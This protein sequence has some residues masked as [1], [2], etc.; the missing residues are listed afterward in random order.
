MDAVITDLTGSQGAIPSQNTAQADSGLPLISPRHF[1]CVLHP[2]PDF[3][4]A[5]I[6]LGTLSLTPKFDFVTMLSITRTI[7]CAEILF[8]QPLKK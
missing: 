1:Y 3:G 5:I 8:V 7:T 2:F 6:S 4:K